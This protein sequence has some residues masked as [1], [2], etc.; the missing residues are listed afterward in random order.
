MLDVHP[1]HEAAHTWR[2]FFI[3]IA[4]I[5]VG[6]CI[7]VGLEQT[8]EF[9][10]HRHQLRAELHDN[11]ALL[12]IDEQNLNLTERQ[13]EDGITLLTS[14]KAG[15][16]AAEELP[17][18]WV[19]DGPLNAAWDTARDNGAVT[20][21]SYETAQSYAI[22]YTQQ[23]PSTIRRPCTSATSTTSARRCTPT[24]SYRTC[25]PPHWTA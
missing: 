17:L 13:I 9:F 3:H 1:P 5:V 19:W 18:H 8:V 22:V 12:A 14:A 16:A 6:L 20:L 21:M 2:D 24:Q 25:R 7:A 10:H 15:K 11:R 23:K 4:T